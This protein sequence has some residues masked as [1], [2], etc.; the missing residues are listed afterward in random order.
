MR[1]C[2]L[3][4]LPMVINLLKGDMKLVGVRPLSRQYFGLYPPE[5]Q[6][7]RTR[8]KPGLIP[9]FY[10]DLPKT[11]EEIFDSERRYLEAYEKHPFATDL[12]YFFLVIYTI[13]FKRARSN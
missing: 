10:V 9:P 6:E 11:Q 13:V 7:L 4:E 2:W 5:L 3:D 1:K 8:F 12:K